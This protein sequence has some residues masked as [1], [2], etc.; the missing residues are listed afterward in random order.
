MEALKQLSFSGQ[1][2]CFSSHGSGRFLWFGLGISPA[3][4][5]FLLGK[6]VLCSKQL[7][8]PPDF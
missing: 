5:T 4:I 6:F 2:E 3:V 8:F 7:S 1:C